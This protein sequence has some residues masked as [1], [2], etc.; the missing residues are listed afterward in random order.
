MTLSALQKINT[1]LEK[2]QKDILRKELNNSTMMN[3]YSAGEFWVAFNNSAY[4]LHSMMPACAI[5]M[6][7]Q[8]KDN[9]FPVMMTYIKYTEFNKL[10]SANTILKKS[11]NY[12]QLRTAPL[13][14]D[15][16]RQWYNNSLEE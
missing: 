5:S 8:L 7:L 10:L 14:P 2:N 12:T 13:T 6:A 4:Q 1:L 11:L 16:Y 15:A 9:P 3:L